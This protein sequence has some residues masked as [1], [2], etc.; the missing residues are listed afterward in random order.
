MSR[1]KLL[2]LDASEVIRLHELGIWDRLIRACDVH[3]AR[4]VAD[5][6]AVFFEKDG[7]EL[8][9]DLRE[10]R[11]RDRVRVFEVALADINRFRHQFDP[12]YVSE[13]DSGETEALAYLT[14]SFES[15]LISSGDAI[16]FRVLGLLG[17]GE[18]GTSLEEV[19]QRVGMS[20]SNLPWPCRRTFRERYTKEGEADSIRGRGLKR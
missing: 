2:I 13:L 18:Q 3:L 11:D 12:I 5:Q 6:E 7:V 15:F 19:L 17:R 9:I 16:V 8:P 14:Q 1:L 20:Q 4:T 10:D